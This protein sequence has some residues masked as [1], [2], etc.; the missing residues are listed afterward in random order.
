V[1]NVVA[2]GGKTLA[3]YQEL[4]VAVPLSAT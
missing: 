4:N 2:A 1:Y 3:T